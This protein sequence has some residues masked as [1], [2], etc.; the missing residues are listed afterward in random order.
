MPCN[1]HK[2][3]VKFT[4]HPIVN[5][6]FLCHLIRMHDQIRP[7]CVP[8]G[9]PFVR[10]EHPDRVLSVGRRWRCMMFPREEESAV[11]PNLPQRWMISVS[12]SVC[13]EKPLCWR[14]RGLSAWR[15]TEP[16][17]PYLG[18]GRKNVLITQFSY[19]SSIN[20]SIRICR[21]I[22]QNCCVIE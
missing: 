17:T 1:A 13:T 18:N 14:I 21:I 9:I 8:C 3:V 15:M 10:Q 4:L 2:N 12:K 16:P 5:F 7:W 22:G 19:A 11:R 20:V 6:E